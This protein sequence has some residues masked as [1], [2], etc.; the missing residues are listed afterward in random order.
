[1]VAMSTGDLID[2]RIAIVDSGVRF[3]SAGKNGWREA[4]VDDTGGR[5]MATRVVVVGL[6]F[7]I[8]RSLTIIEALRYTATC[9]KVGS[10]IAFETCEISF[11]CCVSVY[12][13]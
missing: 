4:R 1:M 3:S 9:V 10:N 13:S 11:G 7:M 8:D 12:V 5:G 2:S 6:T